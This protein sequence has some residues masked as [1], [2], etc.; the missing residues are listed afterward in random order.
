MLSEATS[1][2]S[3]HFAVL[4][5]AAA[6][7]PASAA[8]VILAGSA[9][10]A[11]KHQC[12]LVCARAAFNLQIHP[13]TIAQTHR[14]SSPSSAFPVFCSSASNATVLAYRLKN[15]AASAASVGQPSNS[16]SETITNHM[17]NDLSDC[18]LFLF[19]FSMQCEL[20]AGVA[21]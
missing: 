12:M 3:S 9:C 5:E 18:V 4:S 8:C 16:A 21:R 19:L 11:S 17:C 7:A 6:P 20:F 13:I 14:T 15:Q 1:Q 2:V 10:I